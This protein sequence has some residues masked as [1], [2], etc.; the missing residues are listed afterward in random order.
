MPDPGGGGGDWSPLP[1][2]GGGLITG[3]PDGSHETS[4]G[5][6]VHCNGSVPVKSSTSPALVA[7]TEAFALPL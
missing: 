7:V 3:S 6:G 4:G 5:M 2:G 1:D